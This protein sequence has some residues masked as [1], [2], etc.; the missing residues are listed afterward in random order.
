AFTM[1]WRVA[2][3][4]LPPVLFLTFMVPLTAML[5]QPIVFGAQMASVRLADAYLHL[6]GFETHRLGVIIQMETFTLQVRVP[7]SGFKTMIA[8]ASFAACFIYLLSGSTPKKLVLFGAA[9]VLS[10][11]VNGLR[12]ALVG[13]TGELVS[14]EAGSWVHDNGGLPVTV[15]ALGAL[16]W[17]ARM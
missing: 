12:I 11:V 17:L 2:S 7:C 4:L 9:L 8:L 15:L 5:T 3:R 16:F 1:G 14:H 6:L 10:L 13:V